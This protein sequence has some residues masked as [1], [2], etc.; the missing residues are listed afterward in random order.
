MDLIRIELDG[1][2]LFLVPGVQGLRSDL[3]G[4][5]FRV[6]SLGLGFKVERSGLR[7]SGLGFKV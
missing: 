4:L 1:S 7:V 5:G 2:H 3:K 6:S